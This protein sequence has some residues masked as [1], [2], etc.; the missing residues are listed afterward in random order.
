MKIGDLVVA[1]H[2][3]YTPTSWYKHL[4][5]S[6]EPVVVVKLATDHYIEIYYRDGRRLCAVS[7]L[8]IV[9]RN[10]DR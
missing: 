3:A 8:K 5:E 6:Q 10:E 2:E 1:I 4:Y 7:N 9:S